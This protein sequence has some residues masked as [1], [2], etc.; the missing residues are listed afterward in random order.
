MMEASQPLHPAMTYLSLC[1]AVDPQV[2]SGQD[3]LTSLSVT[4]SLTGA[5]PNSYEQLYLGLTHEP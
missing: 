4:A 2:R 3:G 1:S 5:Q